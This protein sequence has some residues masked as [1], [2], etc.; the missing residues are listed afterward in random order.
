MM[1]LMQTSRM[2]GHHPEQKGYDLE[3]VRSSSS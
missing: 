1:E 2:A 3:V